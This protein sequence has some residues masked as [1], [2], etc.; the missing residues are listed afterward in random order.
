MGVRE[1]FLPEAGMHTL[2]VAG[3]PPG[4]KTVHGGKRRRPVQN[5]RPRTPRNAQG[6]TM[7]NG[8]HIRQTV[9]RIGRQLERMAHHTISIDIAFDILAKK[10]QSIEEMVVIE[11]M[12]EIY[13]EMR[14]RG[15]DALEM[16]YADSSTR[17]ARTPATALSR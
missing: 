3:K 14:S 10:S 16:H 17:S 7:S 2:R 8:I 4:E 15:I 5:A 11:V 1:P 12:R 13:L 6:G 9:H